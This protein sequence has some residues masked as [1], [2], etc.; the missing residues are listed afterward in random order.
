[1]AE[2]FETHGGGREGT[3]RVS[4]QG[5]PRPHKL[6]SS[7]GL[8]SS[9]VAVCSTCWDSLGPLCSESAGGV[10]PTWRKCGEEGG[11]CM[12]RSMQ[13]STQYNRDKAPYH[14]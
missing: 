10:D 9:Y 11:S 8:A 1:M 6:V 3:I 13:L 14:T 7:P 2:E 12:G 4:S 5:A